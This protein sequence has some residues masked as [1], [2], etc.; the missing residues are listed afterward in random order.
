[1][2]YTIYKITNKINNKEYI[3][4]HQTNNLDDGYMGSGKN[5]KR[6]VDKYG[7]E[8]FTKEILFV[9]DSE[10]EMNCKESE[11][12][13]EEYCSRKDTYNICVGGK[14]GW[15]YINKEIW[16]DEKRVEHNRKYSIFDKKE[17]QS[18]LTHRKEAGTKGGIAKHKKYA[19]LYEIKFPD[20]NLLEI[21][22]LSKF[23]RE[24]NLNKGHMASIAR[25]ERKHHKGFSCRKKI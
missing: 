9:L 23:C 21:D 24:N 11:I 25:G 7:V 18:S 3:G 15:S 5:L 19:I 4:K 8:N 14:G 2:F 12:V 6:A 13:T 17:F 20:G 22:N 1:M 16:K 10:D